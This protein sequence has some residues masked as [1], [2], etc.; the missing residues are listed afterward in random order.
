[1]FDYENHP[2]GGV[3]CG[4]NNGVQLGPRVCDILMF[5]AVD[6]IQCHN[7][8]QRIKGRGYDGI[9]RSNLEIA[10]FA[11]FPIVNFTAMV[12]TDERWNCGEIEFFVRADELDAIMLNKG[13]WSRIMAS[14]IGLPPGLD[15]EQALEALRN[16]EGIPIPMDQVPPEVREAMDRFIMGGMPDDDDGPEWDVG[17]PTGGYGD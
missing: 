7:Y 1:M 15:P 6:M 16:G 11:G 3:Y 10:D 8:T 2:T 5:N 13:V 9:I 12:A 17:E 14:V 4:I